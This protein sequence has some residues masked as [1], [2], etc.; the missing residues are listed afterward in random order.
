[1]AN[2]RSVTFEGVLSGDMECFCWDNVTD[3]PKDDFG[4]L[5]RVYPNDVLWELDCK[6]GKRYRFTMSVEEISDGE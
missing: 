2:Q 5:G 4:V 1:M 3:F 6:Q